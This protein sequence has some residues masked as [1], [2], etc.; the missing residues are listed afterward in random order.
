M[1]YLDAIRF[2]GVPA[3]KGEQTHEPYIGHE[4]TAV[5]GFACG[6]AK[7]ASDYRK[8]LQSEGYEFNDWLWHSRK[9]L[10]LNNSITTSFE[11]D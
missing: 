8:L 11:L 1:Q 10:H 9:R 5:Y 7:I 6:N 4:K 2:P 3:P